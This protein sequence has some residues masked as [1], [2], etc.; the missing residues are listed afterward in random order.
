M[1][2]A[3]EQMLACQHNKSKNIAPIKHQRVGIGIVKM[4]AR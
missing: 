2:S 1:F 3:S 4:S